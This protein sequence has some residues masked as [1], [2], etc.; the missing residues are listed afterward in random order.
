MKRLD[1]Y[2]ARHVIGATLLAWLLVTALDSLF[3]LLGELGDIGRGRY[4]LPTALV[5]VLLTVPAKAYQLFPMAALLG[6]LLGLGALAAHGE[7]VAIRLGGFSRLRLLR[8]VL[9]SGLLMLLVAVTLGET[10][11]PV[12]ERQARQLRALAIFDRVAFAGEHGLWVRDG[13]RFINVGGMDVDGS[14]AGVFIFEFAPDHRLLSATRA[15]NAAYTA[16]GWRLGSLQQSLFDAQAVRTRASAGEPWQTRITP[17]LVE[18]LALDPDAMSLG[19]LRGYI[20]YLQGNA[21]DADRYRLAFWARLATP[22]SALVMLALAVGFVL[23]ALRSVGTG[24]RLFAGILIGLL[25]R[26]M[27]DLLAQAGLVYGLPPVVSAFSPSAG[28]MLAAAWLLRERTGT[29]R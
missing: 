8:S 20:R 6:A 23:G 13:A 4:D 27:N 5:Y 10:L 18:V 19:E 22:S 14:L 26:L 25:F 15:D 16:S 24:Q 21:L 17:T 28:F 1:R 9:Q 12:A 29:V 11:A 3:A 7:L 2:I